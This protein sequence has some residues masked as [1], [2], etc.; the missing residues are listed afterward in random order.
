ME[1]GFNIAIR[2]PLADTQSISTLAT[3]GEALGF[4]YLAIPDHIVIPTSIASPYP[5]SQNRKMAGANLGHCMEPLT[6]MTY[7]AAI[8]KKARLL[9]SVMVVPHRP[10]LY[11]AKVLATIDVLSNGRVTV[12]V[13][14]GWM[15]EEF[16]ALGAPPFAERG[17]VTD[18]YLDAFKELWT[19][20]DPRFDGKY[21]RFN[22]I[23]FLPKPV[24]RPHPP[25]WVGGESPAAL[26]RTARIGDAWYPIGTNPQFPL[27][28]MERLNRGIANLRQEAEKIGRDPKSIGIVYW[29]NWYKENNLITT[30]NDQ[31]QL[32][33]GSDADVVEDILRFKAMGMKE[34]LFSFQR[35]TLEESLAAMERFA[36]EIMPKVR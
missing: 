31:R 12:G 18:E 5:Y 22:N 1:F 9:T 15:D 4:T 25:I 6:V 21:V 14:A 20:A 19:Q 36:S 34:L 23:S 29:A 28:T 3:K 16:Q 2:G 7:L 30:D 17:K 26:R 24:Q 32:F 10:A 27:N 11:A 35:A 13:G 33:T 8:T